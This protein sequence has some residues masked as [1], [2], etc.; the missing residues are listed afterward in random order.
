MKDKIFNFF[1]FLF[2]QKISFST[3][4][5]Y[6]LD[7]GLEC[8]KHDADSIIKQ[9]KDLGYEL[10]YYKIRTSNFLN[11]FQGSC[12]RVKLKFIKK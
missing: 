10:Y 2:A 9:Y 12:Y 8:A 7:N 3:A 6:Y 1:K 5:Y 11:N 4:E